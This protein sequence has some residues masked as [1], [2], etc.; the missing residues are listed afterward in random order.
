MPSNSRRGAP[1]LVVDHP[2]RTVSGDIEPVDIPAKDEPVDLGLDIQ[3]TLGRLEPGWS[4]VEPLPD[5][6]RGAVE[7]APLDIDLR[8]LVGAGV[9]DPGELSLL[10]DQTR[11]LR[12]DQGHG[13]GDRAARGQVEEP[14][15]HGMDEGARAAAGLGAVGMRSTTRNRYISG[16]A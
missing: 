1:G 10:L 6:R 8:D 2:Q 12:P 9:E 11:P 4:Q 3:L 5:Q 13:G 16:T 14:L 15:E 7:P